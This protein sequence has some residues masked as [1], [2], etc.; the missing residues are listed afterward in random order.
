LN[1]LVNFDH[2][3]LQEYFHGERGHH[4]MTE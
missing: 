3:W 1:T 4:A 2:P